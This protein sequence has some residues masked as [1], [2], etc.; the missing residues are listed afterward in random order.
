LGY[1]SLLTTPAV[2]IISFPMKVSLDCHSKSKLPNNHKHPKLPTPLP[3]C[4]NGNHTGR[5]LTIPSESLRICQAQKFIS[6]IETLNLE[7]PSH[8][9]LSSAIERDF[10]AMDHTKHDQE[11]RQYLIDQY[12]QNASLSIQQRLHFK[13]LLRHT[14]EE[15][16]LC[17]IV[18]VNSF[19]IFPGL[20]DTRHEIFAP[21]QCRYKFDSPHQ[22]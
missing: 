15:S 1:K 8:D 20:I 7:N 21:Y 2:E 17:S 11:L 3:F 5:Y 19:H 22:V 13:E 9:I 12:Q 14:D 16:S 18:V 10:I 6:I 4:S